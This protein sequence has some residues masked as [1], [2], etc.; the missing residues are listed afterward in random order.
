MSVKFRDYYEVL[1]VS[2]EATEKEIKTAYR[3]LARKHHPDL[4]PGEEKAKAE[5]KFKQINEAYE[6]LS[7]SEKRKKYDRLGERWQSGEDFHYEQQPGFEGVRFYSGGTGQSG[8]SD[9]FET[10]F[11]GGMKG[12]FSGFDQRD[13]GGRPR[14]GSDVE[15]E[16][17]LSL[18]EAYHG[19]EKT[20]QLNTKEI[21]AGCGGSGIRGQGICALCAGTGEQAQPKTLSVKIPAGTREG[22]RIRLRG[23]GGSGSGG[24]RGDLY[25]KVRLRPHPVFTVKGDDLEAELTVYPWQAV[26]G[27]K[28]EAPTLDGQVTVTVPAGTHSGRRLRL[29]GRGLPLKEGTRGDLYLKVMIDVPRNASPDELELYRQLAGLRSGQGV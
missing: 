26:L 16:I 27:E 18:E 8:F 3:K 19:V 20:L 28:V 6:V 29:R 23:Q 4:H 1:G 15:A 11:G 25:L 14:R 13:F 17:E 10:L 24:V 5:E 12:A 21:C 7:D 2:R 22:A 9:F